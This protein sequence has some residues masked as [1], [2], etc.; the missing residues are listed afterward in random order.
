MK[1]VTGNF[2][3]LDTNDPGDW[4]TI[5][6]VTGHDMEGWQMNGWRIPPATPELV[7]EAIAALERGVG[8]GAACDAMEGQP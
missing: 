5:E 7:A 2:G 3:V 1:I 4:D 6:F 8:A